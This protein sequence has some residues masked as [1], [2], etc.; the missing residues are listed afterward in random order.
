MSEQK[1]YAV[2]RAGLTVV[3]EKIESG[4][5]GTE[6][7]VALMTCSSKVKTTTTHRRPRALTARRCIDNAQKT[8]RVGEVCDLFQDGDH[9]GVT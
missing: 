8:A 6:D 1:L 9:R 7:A 3:V 4:F 2:P 5:V